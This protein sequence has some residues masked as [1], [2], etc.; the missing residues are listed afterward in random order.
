MSTPFEGLNYMSLS[1]S[2]LTEPDH[3]EVTLAYNSDGYTVHLK[4]TYNDGHSDEIKPYRELP[5]EVSTY[6]L[7]GLIN[8]QKVTAEASLATACCFK[9]NISLSIETPFDFLRQAKVFH[10]FEEKYLGEDE[11][12]FERIQLQ[13]ISLVYNEF[14]F[15]AKYNF[16]SNTVM[17]L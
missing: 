12:T 15:A 5:P 11:D 14:E 6:V 17:L 7:E 10:R 4:G 9:Y 1:G 3:Y 16:H 8:D 2:L 13:E